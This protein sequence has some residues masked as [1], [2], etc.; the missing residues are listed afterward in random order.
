MKNQGEMIQPGLTSEE[1]EDEKAEQID[2]HLRQNR[3][4][5]TKNWR[6]RSRLG[7]GHETEG[8]EGEEA[9]CWGGWGHTS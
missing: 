4:K 5:S 1:A 3:W 7:G 6:D 8:D 9:K 2:Q